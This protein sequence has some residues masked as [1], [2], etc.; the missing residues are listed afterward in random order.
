[1][2]S[3][4]LDTLRQK[5]RMRKREPTFKSYLRENQYICQT[6]NIMKCEATVRYGVPVR[7]PDF[8]TSVLLG[9]VHYNIKCEH[10]YMI[11]PVRTMLSVWRF[12]CFDEPCGKVYVGKLCELL[13]LIA[14]DESK[15]EMAIFAGLEDSCLSPRVS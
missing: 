6:S 7:C 3:P 10:P 11:H 13:P 15:T 14:N 4:A 2:K 9:C 1:M 5:A 12:V 8:L